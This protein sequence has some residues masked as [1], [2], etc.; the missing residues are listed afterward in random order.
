MTVDGFDTKSTARQNVEVC[1]S[2][3]LADK[4]NNRMLSMTEIAMAT[5]IRGA[6][7]M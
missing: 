7:L 3:L 6:L 2:G 4:T 1:P 5:N